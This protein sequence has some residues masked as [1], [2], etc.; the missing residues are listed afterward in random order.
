MVRTLRRTL[1]VALAALC[2]ASVVALA[3]DTTVVG[4]IQ[5]VDSNKGRSEERRVRER[6]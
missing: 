5:H 4:T 6:V 2:V 1:A 3:A